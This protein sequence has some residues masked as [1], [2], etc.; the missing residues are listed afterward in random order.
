MRILVLGSGV[1]GV[2]TAYY[3]AKAGHEVTVVERNSESAQET[4]FANG[5]Q[6]SYSHAEPWAHPVVWKKLPKW[7]LDKN[8]PLSFTDPFSLKSW[9]WAAQF[10]AQ[11]THEKNRMGTLN[12]LR[13]ALYSRQCMDNLLSETGIDFHYQDKGILHI[14]EKER[15]LAGAI[16]EA[17]FKKSLGCDY[18]VLSA[19]ECI[20]R[21]P[22]F[23]GKTAERL[24]G[25]IIFPID[26]TGDVCLFTQGLAMAAERTHT[27]VTFKYNTAIYGLTHEGDKITGVVTNDGVL[28]ADAYV[29][30]L[31]SYSPLVLQS[32]GINV[33]IY[34]LKG[35]SISIPVDDHKDAP[36]IGIT[37]Q[38]RKIVYSRL[39][40]IL[41]IAGTAELAGH[42]PK[43]RQSRINSIIQAVKET[44]PD[45]GDF[46]KLTSWACLRSST[47][48]GAP[49]LGESRYDNLFFNTGQ[50]SLG[51]T[52]ACGSSKIVADLIDGKKPDI[53]ITGMTGERFGN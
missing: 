15:E 50:G 24:A 49:V 33:P 36:S 21:E 34:P 51:W 47:P 20:A 35:Y 42:N 53:D 3:L 18:T 25:G 19:A 32:A 40:N 22:A 5:G 44:F 27:K 38:A 10:L 7:L 26:K 14:F 16:Q 37:D 8:S 39:G 2:T 29:V 41:R 12:V 4:S 45:A 17:E 52:L 6:L 48:D 31:G 43:V 9:M 28:Q 46:S 13:L 11:C 1:I 23:R 30:A